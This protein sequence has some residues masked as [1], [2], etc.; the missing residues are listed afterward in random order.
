M[1]KIKSTYGLLIT[2]ILFTTLSCS[3]AD[4]EEG[5]AR[6]EAT[7]AT[8][9]DASSEVMLGETIVIRGSFQVMS[10]CGEFGRFTESGNRSTRVIEI[11]AKYEGVFCTQDLP[12]R[13]ATYKYTPDS[14]GEYVFSRDL[15]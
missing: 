11:E 6:Y 1:S 14:P 5:A 7:Y 2:L 12:L 10:G 13:Q 4:E 8:S 3:N 9:L 15:I